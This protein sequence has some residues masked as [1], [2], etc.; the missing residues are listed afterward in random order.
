MANRDVWESIISA[1]PTVSFAATSD[2][3]ALYLERFRGFIEEI[4]A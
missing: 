2:D 3:V 1:G 4:A